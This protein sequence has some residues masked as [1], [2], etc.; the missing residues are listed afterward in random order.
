LLNRDAGCLWG[1]LAA[2]GLALV[3]AIRENLEILCGRG[4]MLV[5]C[6][7]TRFACALRA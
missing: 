6:A 7:V 4:L 5:R 1:Q 3:D 2:L